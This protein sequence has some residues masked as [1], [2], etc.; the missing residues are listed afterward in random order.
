MTAAVTNPIESSPDAT[1][2]LR[3][4]V[5]YLRENN[6]RLRELVVRL[7]AS[8]IKEIYA[9]HAHQSGQ[10]RPEY[11]LAAAETCFTFARLPNVRP[12]LATA[13]QT[14]GEELSARA[15]RLDAERE[16]SPQ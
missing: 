10:M 6:E 11:V 3:K 16:R 13:F 2:E 9:T 4:E 1:A 5:Q 8:V 12:K 14:F 15:V 7:T